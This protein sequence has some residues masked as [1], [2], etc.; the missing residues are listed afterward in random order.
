M[1]K[2]RFRRKVRYK[3]D[4]E[5][6]HFALRSGFWASAQKRGPYR[7]GDWIWQIGS[8]DNPLY[9][10]VYYGTIFQAAYDYYYGNRFRLTSPKRKLLLEI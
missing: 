3:M 9:R 8:K 10:H 5:R 4:W 1:F 2:S 7:K 6:Y